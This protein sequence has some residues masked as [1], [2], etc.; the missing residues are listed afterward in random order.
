[1]SQPNL[2]EIKDISIL[3]DKIELYKQFIISAN[4]Q[5][6]STKKHFKNLELIEKQKIQAD[7]IHK[8]SLLQ[9]Q[10]DICEYREQEQAQKKLLF[11]QTQKAFEIFISSENMQSI[12][13]DTMKAFGD[14]PFEIICD[15]K[16]KSFLSGAE[17][18]KTGTSGQLRVSSK[19]R[20]YILDPE[21]LR[22]IFFDRFIVSFTLKN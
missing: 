18:I 12:I 17:N 14:E 1:M 11:S 10:N 7:L 6:E 15:P 9:L 13:Q 2:Q 16:F 5:L 8:N 20:E 21:Y 19:T 4:K 3:L 22:A